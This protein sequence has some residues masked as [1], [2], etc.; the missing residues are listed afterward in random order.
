MDNYFEEVANEIGKDSLEYM[1]LKKYVTN[2]EQ[3]KHFNKIAIV[4]T[5]HPYK[6][7]MDSIIYFIE[8]LL[9]KNSLSTS[10]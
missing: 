5:D 9:L 4:I 2:K 7:L 10:H 6:P 3:L 1:L 8:S